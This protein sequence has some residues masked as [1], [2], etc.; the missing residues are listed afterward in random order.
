V[1]K[2]NDWISV[3]NS[4]D[5]PEGIMKKNLFFEYKIPLM[6]S[7]VGIVLIVGG[8]YASGLDGSTKTSEKQ[9]P[10]PSSS[11]YQ[12]YDI[13]VDISGAVQVP[14]V[15]TLNRDSRVEDILK[16]AGG[17]VANA[18]AEYISKRLNLSQK[19]TDGQKIYIPFTGEGGAYQVTSAVAGV[20]STTAAE[21]ITGKVGLNSATPDQLDTLPGVGP[22]TAGKIISGRPYQDISDLFNKKIV[23]RSVFEKVKDL[24]DLN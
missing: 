21:S 18:D 2:V 9:L 11:A 13:K 8:V 3:Y 17:F 20:Q 7:L 14:G 1:D 24:V 23:S 22:V 19:L 10:K 12:P 4:S 5:K 15:Y 6:L 16:V